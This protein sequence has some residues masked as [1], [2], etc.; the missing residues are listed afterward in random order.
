MKKLLSL[1]MCYVFLQAETFA[2]RGGPNSAGGAKVVGF[3]SGVMV[4]TSGT[5]DVGLFLL[6][7]AA[8]GASNGQMVIY[9]ASGVQAGG[10]NCT[11]IGLSDTSRGGSGKFI[12]VFSGLAAGTKVGEAIAGQITCT[13]NSAITASPRLVGTANSRTSTTS[14]SNTGV[15]NTGTVT[16]GPL[17]DYIVDGYNTNGS[18]NGISLFLP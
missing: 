16:A 3:Y 9:T 7:A 12:G 6:N 2:L 8:G 11:I 1:L 13:V 5:G 4:E 18:S 15:N 10:Y 17:R 14:T